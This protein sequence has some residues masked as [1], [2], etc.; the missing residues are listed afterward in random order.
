MKAEERH[1][2]KDNEL[3]Q[4]LR[5]LPEWARQNTRQIVLICGIIAAA[6]IIYGWYYYEKNIAYVSRRQAFSE[7]I[8]QLNAN[9]R[10]AATEGTKAKDLSFMLAQSGDTLGQLASRAKDKDMAALAYVKRG[11]ALRASVHYKPTQFTQDM[12]SQ[13]QLARDSYRRAIELASEN[14]TIPALA[15]YGLGLC[16]EE[17]QDYQVAEQTYKQIVADPNLAG[18]VGQAAAEYRLRTFKD[19]T[20]KVVF[21]RIPPKAIPDVNALAQPPADQQVGQSTQIPSDANTQAR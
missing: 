15:M 8:M 13:I 12:A 10:Q 4:W 20:A 5:Q 6:V 1:E 16:A 7:Q 2:L 3:A 14:P 18:T 9:K 21:R 11:E 17:L 19:Y